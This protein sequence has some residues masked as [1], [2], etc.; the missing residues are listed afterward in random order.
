MWKRPIAVLLAMVMG[1]VVFAAGLND[2][3]KEV[4]NLEIAYWEY[5]KSNDIP[6]YRS[7][8]DERFVGWP[9]FSEMPLGKANIHEWVAELHS[10][11]GTRVEYELTI[12]SV[13]AFGD[14]V[15]T[16]YLVRFSAR[17]VTTGEIVGDA[18]VSRITHTWQRHGDSWRIVTGMSGSWIGEGGN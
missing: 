14:I 1:S 9:G 8:W 5:V 10:N 16:H 15:A 11:P 2:D 7:L 17:S 13:R 18:V 4:W 12:G 3:E 6:S